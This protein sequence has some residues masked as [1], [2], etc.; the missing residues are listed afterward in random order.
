MSEIRCIDIVKGT[1][2]IKKNSKDDMYFEM[3]GVVF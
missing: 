3:E 1:N 2:N